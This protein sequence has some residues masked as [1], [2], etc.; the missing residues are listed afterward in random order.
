[1]VLSEPFGSQKRRENIE[2]PSFTPR[3]VNTANWFYL[4]L[5]D[6][7]K[8]EK[9]LR[10]RVLHPYMW[11]QRIGFIWTFW[12]A[13]KKRKCSAPN[14]SSHSPNWYLVFICWAIRSSF[15]CVV[16]RYFHFVFDFVLFPWLD[17]ILFLGTTGMLCWNLYML[18][19]RSQNCEKRLLP[20]S[21]VSVRPSIRMEQL[22]VHWTDFCEIW[23]LSM[24][25]ISVD[26]IQVSLK[27]DKN[28]GH[29]TWRP[30]YIFDH[31]SLS[32]S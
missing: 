27:S 24:F 3:H 14:G 28:N 25:R 20:S 29:F 15:V 21:R 12:F 30:I 6:R 18:R 4:S 26:K 22:D 11:T 31:I 7:R 19:A 5:L 2:K 32:S 9:I 1:L 10:N 16:R 13:E 23:Y 17:I 8:E